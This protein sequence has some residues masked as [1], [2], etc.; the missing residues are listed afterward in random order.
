MRF[1]LRIIQL[2]SRAYNSTNRAI[3]VTILHD[4]SS[5]NIHFS[6]Q[7]KFKICAGPG[8]DPTTFL[9]SGRQ[10]TTTPEVDRQK[11]AIDVRPGFSSSFLLLL[12]SSSPSFLTYVNFN[13]I[14]AWTTHQR[15]KCQWQSG[16]ICPGC[17]SVGGSILEWDGT[18]LITLKTKSRLSN[19]VQKSRLWTRFVLTRNIP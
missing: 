5:I 16:S 14:L 19:I 3:E 8:F 11:D 4:V 10:V 6:N 9:I 2:L 7:E 18:F 13:I 1:D 12:L 15:C 17:W